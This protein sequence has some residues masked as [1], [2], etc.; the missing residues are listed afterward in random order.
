[1]GA[2]RSLDEWDKSDLEKLVAKPSGDAKEEEGGEDGADPSVYK[3]QAGYKKYI[4]K[5][6]EKP[7]NSKMRFLFFTRFVV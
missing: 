1:M 5:R 7:I 6:E 2:T 3:G 4:K